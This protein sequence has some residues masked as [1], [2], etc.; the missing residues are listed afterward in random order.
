MVNL[1][2]ANGS[3]S[4]SPIQN[5]INVVVSKYAKMAVNSLLSLSSL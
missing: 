5:E 2:F 4:V 1:L 3:A